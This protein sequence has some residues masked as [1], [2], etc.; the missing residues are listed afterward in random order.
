MSSPFSFLRVKSGKL[1]PISMRAGT[2]SAT[3]A[4]EL[5]L[6]YNP[7]TKAN[8]AFTSSSY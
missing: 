6:L 8:S 1:P 5:A 3:S 2:S 4:G 7:R